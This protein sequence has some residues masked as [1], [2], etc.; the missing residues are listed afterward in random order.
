MIEA[1]CALGDVVVCALGWIAGKINMG[2]RA[3]VENEGL[4][5]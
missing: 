5:S 4:S 1:P 3:Y 2:K